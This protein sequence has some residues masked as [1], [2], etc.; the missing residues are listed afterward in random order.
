MFPEQYF[1]GGGITLNQRFS[2]PQAAAFAEDEEAE[3]PT[4]NQRFSAH[5][6]VHAS[7]PHGTLLLCCS[8]RP[9]P[10]LPSFRGFSVNV[11]SLLDEE[12]PSSSSSASLLPVNDA[13][14]RRIFLARNVS[15]GMWC[16]GGAAG[17]RPGRPETRPGEEAAGADRGR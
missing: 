5:Q 7:S 9:L 3:K 15:H 4:L 11:N 10:C 1:G 14:P 8:R 16:W 13:V 17:A 12:G 2:A 6:C